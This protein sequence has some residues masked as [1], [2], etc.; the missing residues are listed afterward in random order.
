VD[1]IYISHPAVPEQSL[2]RVGSARMPTFLAARTFGL[3]ERL[4]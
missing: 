4:V 2:T 3:Y 1:E